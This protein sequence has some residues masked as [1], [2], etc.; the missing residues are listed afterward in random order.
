MNRSAFA[1]LV[2]GLRS[3]S[4]NKL[5]HNILIIAALDENI[6]NNNVNVC[7]SFENAERLNETKGEVALSGA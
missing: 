2:K 6:S 5:C 7:S 1:V 3:N 4:N